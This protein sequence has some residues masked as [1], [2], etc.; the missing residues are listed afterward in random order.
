MSHKIGDLFDTNGNYAYDYHEGD[1]IPEGFHL[2]EGELPKGSF[3]NFPKLVIHED[4]TKEIVEA[5][6]ESLI[7]DDYKQKKIDEMD[8][9][10]KQDII[11]GFDFTIDNIVYH[12]S[13][14]QEAQLN[15]S[16]ANA[17]LSEGL[18]TSVEWT[19]KLNGVY[20]R[21]LLSKSQF[22]QIKL[23]AFAEKDRKVKKFR[24]EIV[25][26]ILDTLCDTREKVDL[27]VW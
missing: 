21:I 4:G 17:L 26:A 5:I 18:I 23:T 15:F 3:R 1:A 14:D 25:P 12:F 11:N 10:C 16:G 7:L 24:N 8:A 13:F 2:W 20:E 9:A 6:H 19:V 27:I 22:D